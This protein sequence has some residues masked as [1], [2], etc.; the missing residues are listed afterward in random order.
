MSERR[1][2]WGERL[3][4]DRLEWEQ[5]YDPGYI[6]D[7]CRECA[8]F[9]EGIS[10][11][12]EYSKSNAMSVATAEM[13]RRAEQ[14]VTYWQD[15]VE[16]RLEWRV[17]TERLTAFGEVLRPL[18]DRSGIAT[19]KELL[20]RAGKQHAPH[21]VETLLRHMHSPPT[22]LQMGYLTGIDTALGL[23]D[24]QEDEHQRTRL[25]TPLM[26]G[27]LR[28]TDGAKVE[29]DALGAANRALSEA[30]DALERAQPRDEAERERNRLA[31]LAISEAG[32]IVAK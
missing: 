19:T 30:G 17:K 23:G 1:E 31:S 28:I 3:C 32:M 27:T 18:M 5:E 15:Q 4:D 14:E 6:L 2:F 13:H 8:S 24:S 7:V 10:H 26:Y 29:R 16:M 22:E 9:L 12:G 25:S 11:M 21:A 20:E